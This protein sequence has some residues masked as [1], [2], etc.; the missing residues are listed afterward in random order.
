MKG[1][2]NLIQNL[3]KMTFGHAH[4]VTWK[5]IHF[6]PD[7]L[8]AGL[9]DMPGCLHWKGLYA[10]SL[11]CSFTCI[12]TGYWRM[13]TEMTSSLSTFCFCR[14]SMLLRVCTVKYYRRLYDVARTS[15][16]HSAV[17]C[18]SRFVFHI[19]MSSVI[20]CQTGTATWNLSVHFQ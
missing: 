20:F 4:I 17:H 18:M 12:L 19:V 10:F 9:R 11:I 8:V 7:V 16:T 1:I 3:M 5:T 13:D 15:V 2:G 6:L 14:I